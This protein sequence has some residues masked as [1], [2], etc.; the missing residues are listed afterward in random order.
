M[1]RYHQ[2][3][4]REY[5]TLVHNNS[6]IN[7]YYY[8]IIYNLYKILLFNYKIMVT[9]TKLIQKKP[10]LTTFF[11]GGWMVGTQVAKMKTA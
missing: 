11:Y 9:K 2:D 6:Y 10:I 5:S 4:V 7:L 8:I 1:G 3:H